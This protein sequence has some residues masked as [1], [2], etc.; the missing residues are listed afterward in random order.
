[1]SVK[2]VCVIGCILLGI[3]ARGAAED[4]GQSQPRIWALLVA[5]S[6][7]YINY[8]HQADICHAYQ[9]LHR[10]GV[11]DER[12]VVMM[13]DDIAHSDSNP[14]P[15][16]LINHPNGSNVYEGVIKDYT[17]DEVSPQ[18]FLKVLRGDKEAMHGIGSGKVIDSK[19][20]DRIFVY[21]ADHGAP[22]LIL[23]PTDAYL[24]GKDLVDTLKEMHA[25][26]RFSKLVFYLEACESGSMFSEILPANINVFATTAASPTESSTACYWDE[27]R[28]TYLGDVYSVKWIEDS[29][30]EDLLKETLQTQYQIVKRETKTSAVEEYGDLSIGKM[31]LSKFQGHKKAEPITL[32]PVPCESVDSRQVPVAILKRKI[33]TAPDM[34]TRLKLQNDL[35]QLYRRRSFLERK[36]TQIVN[37]LKYDTSVFE[38]TLASNQDHQCYRRVVD[39]FDEVCFGLGRNPHALGFMHV[40]V[41]M[42]AST[43]PNKAAEI[44]AALDTVCDHPKTE[45]IV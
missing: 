11:P 35:T 43:R 10:H 2:A 3:S 23:F 21:F 8:R 15:G 16:V 31:T 34:D 32:P 24:H 19:P 7:Y 39:R 5:G 26:D 17:G 42:C 38:K 36:M 25:N 44:L 22:N 45:G 12:I 40:F 30:A 18:N 1:M 41:N 14:S 9:V 37:H 13:Y 6:K 33:Q 20:E 28:Q 4:D 27:F 29:D